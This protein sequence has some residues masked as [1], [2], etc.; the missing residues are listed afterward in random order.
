MRVVLL[1]CVV[2]VSVAL[3]IAPATWMRDMWTDI[4]NRT[5]AQVTLPGTH[6]AG[7][8]NLTDAL[9]PGDAAGV[10]AQRFARA[11]F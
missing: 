4:G 2:A 6:D 11:P 9:E 5:L 7:A 3:P 8:Y 1:V 10:R